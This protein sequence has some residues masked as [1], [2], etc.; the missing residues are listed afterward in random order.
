MLP[1]APQGI[2]QLIELVERHFHITFDDL[3]LVPET[4]SSVADLTELVRLKLRLR[5]S[6]GA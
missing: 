3:E 5:D 6:D 1:K 4:F 2:E